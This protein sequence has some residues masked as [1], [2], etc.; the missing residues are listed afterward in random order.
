MVFDCGARKVMLDGP[1]IRRELDAVAHVAGDV[2]FGGFYTYGEIA[3]T[4]G[5]RGMHHL[6]VVTLALA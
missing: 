6:T 1:G 3:R 4:Q 5:S 2:P